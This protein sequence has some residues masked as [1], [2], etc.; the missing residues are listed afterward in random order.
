MFGYPIVLGIN[1]GM[2]L[3]RAVHI[4]AAMF[5]KPCPQEILK[6]NLYKSFKY[7][8]FCLKCFFAWFGLAL[9]CVCMFASKSEA[10]EASA[11]KFRIELLLENATEAQ[12]KC[13]YAI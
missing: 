13:Q 4:F 3:V 9:L 5:I 1:E 10:A 11:M 12:V 8:C 7:V 6:T 2:G